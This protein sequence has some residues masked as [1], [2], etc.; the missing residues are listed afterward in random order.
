VAPEPELTVDQLLQEARSKLERLT[1][2]D[3]SVALDSGAI[4][5]DIRSE[6]QRSRDGELPGAKC[7]QRNVLEWRLDPSSPDRDPEAARRDVQLIVICNQGYQSSLAAATLQRFGLQATD[8]IGGFQGWR[9]AGQPVEPGR[10][11]A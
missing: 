9:D 7:F 6:R 4:L 8:V 11:E 5:I 2:P 10:P 3:A 1:P